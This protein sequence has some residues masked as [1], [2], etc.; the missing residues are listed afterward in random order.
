[1]LAATK[2]SSLT[3]QEVEPSLKSKSTLYTNLDIEYDK[4][5]KTSKD[6]IEEGKLLP[7]NI[8]MAKYYSCFQDP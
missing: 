2:Q 4:L 8:D 6:Y 1:M 7:L 5:E 3:E